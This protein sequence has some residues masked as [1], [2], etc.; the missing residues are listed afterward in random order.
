LVAIIAM[1]SSIDRYRASMAALFQCDEIYLCHSCVL[2]FTFLS[3]ASFF[4]DLDFFSDMCDLLS[5]HLGHHHGLGTS[6][7]E[8][9]GRDENSRR[10]KYLRSKR[11]SFN[12]MSEFI[13]AIL[14]GHHFTPRRIDQV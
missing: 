3:I 13:V 14:V 5:I 4:T 8:Q 10:T 7:L 2:T 9:G 11:L 6:Y 12:S 1:P